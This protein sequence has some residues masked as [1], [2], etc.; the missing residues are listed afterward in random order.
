MHFLEICRVC[1]ILSLPLSLSRMLF[2]LP[3]TNLPEYLLEA[4]KKQQHYESRSQNNIVDGEL[5]FL[6]SFY[7]FIND[8]NGVGDEASNERS[9]Y[10]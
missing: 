5:F 8:V 4:K 10:S 6:C 2:L 3:K 9:F 7:A 1:F